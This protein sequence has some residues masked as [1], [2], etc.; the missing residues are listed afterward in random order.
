V[1][2]FAAAMAALVADSNLG[3]DAVY[4]SGGT[5]DPIAVRVLRSSP[6]VTVNAFDA[7]VVQA[8]D[9]LTVLMATLPY[10]APGDTFS[11]GADALTVKH[12]E[13]SATGVASTAYCRRD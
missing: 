2:A 7:Q 13:R 12:V 6:D 10:L 3:V 9:V 5:G 1:N 8:T 4:R 11:I